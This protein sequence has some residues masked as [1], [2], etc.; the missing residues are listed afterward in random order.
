LAA[1]QTRTLMMSI[2]DPGRTGYIVAVA[3]NQ[4]GVP[5]QFNWLIG[6]ASLRDQQ[7]HEV[8]Y[9]AVG[10]AKRTGGSVAIADGANFAEINFNGTDYDQLADR[11]AVD[12]IQNQDPVVGPT[13]E[14][15]TRTDVTVYSPLADLRTNGSQSLKISATAYDQ[16]GRSYP[17]IVDNACGLNGS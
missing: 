10:V 8:A 13:Q 11:I 14:G 2:E 15:A 1:N 16:S 5:T 9:N 12:N 4:Q 17:Q 3:V 7:G 6:T